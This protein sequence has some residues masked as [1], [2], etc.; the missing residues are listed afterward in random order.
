MPKT[1]QKKESGAVKEVAQT[2]ENEVD[3]SINQAM[4]SQGSTVQE[5][6][7]DADKKITGSENLWESSAEMHQITGKLT[8]SKN[9]KTPAQIKKE[10]ILRFKQEKQRIRDEILATDPVTEMD[11]RLFSGYLAE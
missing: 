6:E 9:Y 8:R 2:P 10:K 4:K 3:L 7:E 5:S 1:F 11:T